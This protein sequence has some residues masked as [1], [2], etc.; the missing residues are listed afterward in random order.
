MI[1][2]F[3]AGLCGDMCGVCISRVRW[4]LLVEPVFMGRRTVINRVGIH[5]C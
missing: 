1:V 3:G 5:A 2:C 4:Y